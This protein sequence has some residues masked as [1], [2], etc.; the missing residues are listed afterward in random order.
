MGDKTLRAAPFFPRLTAYLLDRLIL[1]AVL[2]VP[3]IVSAFRDMGGS[4]LS[5]AVLFRFTWS[6][7]VFWAL[8]AAYFVV[9]TAFVGATPGKK[10]MGLMVVNEAGERPD[11]VTVLWRE[12]WARYLSSILC[13]GYI[14][15]A[16]E[17][18]KGALHDRILGTR[19]VYAPPKERTA[20]APAYR[21]AP[22]RQGTSAPALPAG[23]NDDWYAPNI[24]QG[25]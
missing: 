1:G 17:P 16:V 5:R 25:K 22:V 23:G 14:L 12:T 24:Q 20:P 3:R 21:P 10:A 6:D 19:V 9:F 18:E 11:F 13:I 7:I 15:C 8:G 4:A 2:F